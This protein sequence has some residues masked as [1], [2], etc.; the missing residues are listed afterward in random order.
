LDILIDISGERN[1]PI[2]LTEYWNENMDGELQNGS[3]K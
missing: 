1:L 3:K 2:W